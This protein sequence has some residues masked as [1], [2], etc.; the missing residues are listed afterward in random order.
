[1]VGIVLAG[2]SLPRGSQPGQTATTA[3]SERRP[4]P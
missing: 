3:A 2:G 4:A 1:V